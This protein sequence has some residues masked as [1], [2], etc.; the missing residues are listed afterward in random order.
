MIEAGD[1][2]EFF[3]AEEMAVKYYAIGSTLKNQ[4]S[5]SVG[6][7]IRLFFVLGIF[8]ICNFNYKSIYFLF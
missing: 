1:G 7:E 8:C 5:S 3:K 2:Q 6:F 4:R